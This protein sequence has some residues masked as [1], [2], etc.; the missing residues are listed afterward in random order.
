MIPDPPGALDDVVSRAHMNDAEL[1]SFLARPLV[2]VIASTRSDGSAHAVPVWYRYGAGA[3]H[4]WTDESR[5]WVRNVA[6]RPQVS[7]C[8]AEHEPPYAA[9]ILRGAASVR[10]GD[11]APITDEIR[12][13]TARYI[14]SDEVDGYIADW[15]T[16]RTIVTVAVE[17]VTS[18]GRGY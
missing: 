10:S 15:S 17:G 18:W 16:L 8:I 4:I 3:L 7:V 11:A 9:V 12:R 14:A 2:A 1:E 6:A 13:I 5:R